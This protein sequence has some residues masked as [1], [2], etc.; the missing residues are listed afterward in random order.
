LQR[1]REK[2]GK[3]WEGRTGEGRKEEKPGPS[4]P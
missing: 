2:K 4:A 3:E 1:K